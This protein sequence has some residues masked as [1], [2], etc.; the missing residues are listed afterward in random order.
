M[1]KVFF[2]G[3]KLFLILLFFIAFFLRFYNFPQNLFFG[4]EQGRDFL[5]IKNIALD[6]NLTLIGSK[7]D[8]E[9]V[10]HG[11]IYY[12]LA[13]IPFLISN[14]NPI[15]VSFFFI[16]IN[17]IS[18]FVIFYLGKE[19]FSTRVG[20]FSA[21]L[22][23]VSFGSIIYSRWLSNPPL[24]IFLSGLYFLFIYRFLR[25]DSLS[26]IWASIVFFLLGQ[27]EVL[28]FI[29]FGAITL[30]III[31]FNKEFRKSKLSIL[32]ISL[33]T[34][35]IGSFGNYVLFDLRHGFLIGKSVL[36]LI[37]G[38]TGYYI[39][40]SNA[41]VSNTI[42]FN[43]FFSN[44][45][46]PFQQILS[47]FM[48]V[49]GI[50]F[51]IRFLIKQFQRSTILLLLWLVV[52]LATLVLLKH[53]FL[54]HFFIAVGMGA[55]LLA[56]LVLDTMWRINKYIGMLILLLI[57]GFNL[58][59]WQV[60][61]PKN[62]NIFFQSTQLGFKFSDQLKVID[63]L[64]MRANGKPFSF[65]AYTIPYWSPQG[66]EYLF[67]Y[68]GKQKYGYEPSENAEKVFVIIQED[69]SSKH[70]QDVWIKTAVREWGDLQNSFKY[71][72][73]TVMELKAREN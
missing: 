28:N 52:P 68:H 19:F 50:I 41:V 60:S 66:W 13:V 23:T 31:L 70:Y 65:H 32:I 73:L 5:V 51:S 21:I 37:S 72:D 36:R 64:Y 8:I 40:Y 16:L 12:Y 61:I 67:W 48:L 57:I 43:S 35:T 54:E 42:G 55:L 6:H 46:I 17:C 71:G 4:P 3:E 39:P 69:P 15:F 24:S 18:I 33:L 38:S 20:I 10:F 45:V 7:T 58:Y 2:N 62:Y 63:A 11:P 26:L 27:V 44:F 34:I 9:G 25:R 49:L 59:A 1:L 56:A 47:L 14:G 30:L 53:I 22:F 29:F